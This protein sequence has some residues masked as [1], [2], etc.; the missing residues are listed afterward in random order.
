M[1]GAKADPVAAQAKAGGEAVTVRVVVASSCEHD[2]FRAIGGAM[3]RVGAATARVEGDVARV[4]GA[5]AM[6]RMLEMAMT[7]TMA[8]SLLLPSKAAAV[9]VPALGPSVLASRLLPVPMLAKPV[10]GAA[11][12]RW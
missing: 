7:C 8:L 4:A 5:T 9:L 12:T 1:V 10:P 6:A 3:A 2:L 11:G